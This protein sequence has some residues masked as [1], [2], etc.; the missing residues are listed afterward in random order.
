M[1]PS[2]AKDPPGMQIEKSWSRTKPTTPG[3]YLVWERGFG[4]DVLYYGGED[5][6]THRIYG[7]KAFFH[8]PIPN[9]PLSV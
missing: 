8:G 7:D 9:I 3:F 6:P 5:D 1:T 4:F 2:E